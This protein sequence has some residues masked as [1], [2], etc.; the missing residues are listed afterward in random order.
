M[1]FLEV[2]LSTK[3]SAPSSSPGLGNLQQF[4][5]QAGRTQNEDF[6]FLEFGP[7]QPPGVNFETPYYA[8]TL[9][10]CRRGQHQQS[11]P[12][13]TLGPNSKYEVDFSRDLLKQGPLGKPRDEGE[14]SHIV[15]D[16]T[17]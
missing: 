11:V 6:F 13:P 7:G 2:N 1:A 17:V 9:A 5:R 14:S 15:K 3:V 16:K 10:G 8:A 4:W 12:E